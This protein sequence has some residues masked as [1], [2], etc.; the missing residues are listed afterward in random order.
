MAELRHP[1]L[2]QLTRFGTGAGIVIGERDLD[3]CL[4][5]VRPNSAQVLAT[6]R[7]EDFRNRP[8]AEWGAEYAAFLKQHGASHLAALV[9]LPRHEVIVRPVRLPGV[10]GEDAPAAIR[11]QLDS[12]HPFQDEEVVSDFQRAG[13]SDTFIVALAQRNRV[14]SYT[15]LFAESGIKLAGFTFSGGA[16]FP[17]SRLFPSPDAG[18][19]L[20][21][22]GLLAGPEAPVEIY[23]ESGSHPLFSAV[24]DAPAGRAA[25]L[26]SAEMRLEPGHEPRDL[27]DLLPAWQ[28]APESF[29]SSDAGRSRFA[30]LWATALAAACPHLGAPVN[31][32]PAELRSSSS[33]A[34]YIPTI[35][36]SI[37]L[38]LMVVALF[39]QKS[40]MDRRYFGLLDAEIA[41]LSPRAAQVE[42]LDRRIAG[43]SLRIQQIDHFRRR[44]RAHLDI[45]LELTQMLPPPAYLVSLQISPKEVTLSGET[46]QADTLLKKLDASPCFAASEFTMPLARSGTGEVFRI[47]SLR[48]GSPQ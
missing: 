33:R 35:A 31:L 5:R 16:V 17:S 8:A 27:I 40:W 46:E 24:F 20:A 22:T 42:K 43:A 47:R 41:R 10:S 2:R 45:V 48:E 11:F 13:R 14:D 39:A 34:A 23:G 15:A 30:P 12:L 32:L 25:A 7:I 9:L 29:D 6:L 44:T 26:A 28:S 38:A 1:L 4:A 37:I 19:R 36:L 21:V 3:V 18:T